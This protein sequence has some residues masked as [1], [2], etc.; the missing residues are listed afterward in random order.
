MDGIAANNR[1][2]V[3]REDAAQLASTSVKT[4]DLWL[5]EGLPAFKQGKKIFIPVDV[6][7]DWA[8]N[9][10]KNRIGFHSTPTGRQIF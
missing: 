9:R 8:I 10:A 4:I 6:M 5:N 7:R 3:S 1:I 2:L